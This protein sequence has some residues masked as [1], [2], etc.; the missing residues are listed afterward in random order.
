MATVRLSTALSNHITRRASE[1][2][3]VEKSELKW[4]RLDG[5]GHIVIKVDE[6]DLWY[7]N[8]ANTAFIQDV[9]A[10]YR[11]FPNLRV[12]HHTPERRSQAKVV[13]PPEFI[14]FEKSPGLKE[15]ESTSGQTPSA[16]DVYYEVT[17]VWEG[18][19]D[20]NNK[21]LTK[22][23]MN[24]TDNTYYGHDAAAQK[25]KFEVNS[26]PEKVQDELYRIFATKKQ[27]TLRQNVIERTQN[28]LLKFTT[29]NQLVKVWPQVIHLLPE[30]VKDKLA[31]KTVRAKPAPA[32]NNIDMNSVNTEILKSRLGV[33]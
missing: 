5:N 31:E 2:V 3:S 10:V 26:F 12:T 1:A 9:L 16:P 27:M 21:D 6:Y 19:I 32:P 14:D 29:L 13:I 23:F 17:L 20:W 24:P 22:P 11:Q 18:F 4:V 28:A 33:G 30:D 25:V 15:W 8:Y 7:S